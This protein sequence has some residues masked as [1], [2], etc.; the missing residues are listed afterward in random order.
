ME[1]RYNITSGSSDPTAYATIHTTSTQTKTV[2]SFTSLPFG[3]A[4]VTLTSE[5]P[6]LRLA[7]Y[8]VRNSTM[9]DM[10][11]L[12]M[13]GEMDGTMAMDSMM[14]SGLSVGSA[15]TEVSTTTE[16][17]LTSGTDKS[18]VPRSEDSTITTS[19]SATSESSSMSDTSVTGGADASTPSTV[20]VTVT[21]NNTSMFTEHSTTMILTTSTSIVPVTILWTNTSQPTNMQL[22][23]STES[24]SLT[25]S[26]SST[27]GM[28]SFTLMM[29]STGPTTHATQNVV[30]PA[31]PIS[32]ATNKPHAPRS[33]P[34]DS[35]SIEPLT[36]QPTSGAGLYTAWKERISAPKMMSTGYH[37]HCEGPFMAYLALTV[38]VLATW[39]MIGST[40]TR[41]WRCWVLRKCDRCDDELPSYTTKP[42]RPGMRKRLSI[43]VPGSQPGGSSWVSGNQRAVRG[44]EFEVPY[45]R[46]KGRRHTSDL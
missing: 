31:S 12:S 35:A 34:T 6:D 40:L 28:D 16:Q 9:G 32:I 36:P 8:P 29:L 45:E 17:V 3:K 23:N 10:Q 33:V 19:S 27:G 44:D 21:P 20:F 18:V 42:P 39:F 26:D 5:L 14:A 13:D 38:F 11:S 25:T 43:I 22:L 4:Y 7:S 41:W 24:V 46:Y 15:S 30:I 1:S 2:T 37:H